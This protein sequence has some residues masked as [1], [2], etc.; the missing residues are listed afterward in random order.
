MTL[1]KVTDLTIQPERLGRQP[2]ATARMRSVGRPDPGSEKIEY[3][4]QPAE[5][6]LR[7]SHE[8]ISVTR[9]RT[10]A[11]AAEAADLSRAC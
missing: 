9:S 11:R 5:G 4:P 6:L 3:M 2:E 7:H 1:R 10:V 8:M